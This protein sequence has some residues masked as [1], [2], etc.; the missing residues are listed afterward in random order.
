MTNETTET[1]LKAFYTFFYS[2]TIAITSG[3]GILFLLV[4]A[5]KPVIGSLLWS[6]ALSSGLALVFGLTDIRK[7]NLQKKLEEVDN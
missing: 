4:S 1:Y 7:H 3:F 5:D 2:L 6:F